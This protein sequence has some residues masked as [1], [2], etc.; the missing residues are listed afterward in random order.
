MDEDQPRLRHERARRRR[1][2]WG[3]VARSDLILRWT[4]MDVV[5]KEPLFERPGAPK[6]ALLVTA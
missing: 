4:R 1:V 6:Q 5:P 3:V 2:S